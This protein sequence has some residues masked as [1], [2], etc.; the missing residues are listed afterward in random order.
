MAEPRDVDTSYPRWLV[1]IGLSL[2]VI[3]L[4]WAFITLVQVIWFF[5][6]SGVS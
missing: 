1:K 3:E 2:L 4:L 5:A 6:T